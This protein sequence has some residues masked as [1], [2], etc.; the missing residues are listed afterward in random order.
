MIPL[1]QRAWSAA[2]DRIWPRNCP[3]CGK[4]CDRPGH[5]V[6]SACQALLPWMETGGHCTVCGVVSAVDTHD[7]VCDA[8]RA[9][10]PA[11][12]RARAAFRFAEPVRQMILDFKFAR[13]VHLAEDLAEALAGAA[14]TWL[15]AEAVDLVVP[16]PLHPNR[17]RERGYNQSALL[18]E[19]LAERLDRRFDLTSLVRVRDTPH[20]S[21]LDAKERRANLRGAFSCRGAYVR[22]RTVLLVDDV[23]TTGTTLS[24]CAEALK[25]AG[26]A[27]VWCLTLAR[28]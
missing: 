15:E 19:P 9:D 14:R 8:C 11:Y 22:G 28:A 3:G 16:V 10:P 24:A 1:L 25:R 17:F 23:A 7:F 5:H 6:C 20:Q 12:D 4:A 21:R 2:A 13:A 27:R 26:A 18:A